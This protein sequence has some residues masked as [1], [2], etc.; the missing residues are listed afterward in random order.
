MTLKE[1]A[2]EFLIAGLNPLPL[3]E[4]KAPNLPRG[5]QFLYQ[6][7]ESLF[8]FDSAETLKIGI[9][10]G[11]VSENFMCIDFD[12]HQGQNIH[13]IFKAYTDSDYFRLLIKNKKVSTVKT[14]RG[15][16][17]IP[18]RCYET[19]PGCTLARWNDGEVMI[20]IRGEGQYIASFPSKG[21]EFIKGCSLVDLQPLDETEVT[22]LLERAAAFNADGGFKKQKTGST[23]KDSARKWP[24]EWPD[25]TPDGIYNN[26]EAESAKNLL[27]KHGWKL[28]KNFRKID[29]IE[30]WVRP[31]KSEDEGI[32]ATFGRFNNMFY[33]FTDAKSAHPFEDH[34][35]YSPFM[36]LVLLEYGG[37]WK[38]AKDDLCDLYGLPRWEVPPVTKTEKPHITHQDEENESVVYDSKINFPLEILPQDYQNYINATY[39]TLSFSRDFIACTML[40]AIATCIGNKAKIKVKTG[41]V[42]SPIFWM[43]M[44]GSRGANKTHPVKGVLAPLFQL[45]KDSYKLYTAQLEEFNALSEEN[46][47]KTRRPRFKQVVVADFTVEALHHALQFNS[48]GVLLYKDELVG[49]FKDMNKYRKSGGDEEFFLESFNNGS[50]IIN[51]KTQDT[52]RLDHI[53]INVIGT[54]QNGVLTE[55]AKA[56]SENGLLDRFL[57]TKTELFARPLSR[58]N[59]DESYITWWRNKVY[60]IAKEM[61][62]NFPEDTIE[63]SMSDAGYNYMLEVEGKYA[64]IQNSEDTPQ[65]LHAYYSKMRTYF[66]RFAL[67]IM[68]IEHFEYGTDLIIDESHIQKAETL[69]KYFAATA[70]EI[71]SEN[72]KQNEYSEIMMSIRGKSTP[73]KIIALH[74]KGYKQTEISKIMKISRQTV[75]KHIPKK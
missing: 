18:F 46:K 14:P 15:G 63:F 27:S 45:E 2:E 72:S 67:L 47:K 62:Y 3:R 22:F 54:I 17:H 10:C 44:V 4:N 53:F 26:T 8:N 49:F 28:A 13:E 57:F 42:D 74:N 75:S 9:A 24:D 29:D 73:E 1:T 59:L 55:L 12:C 70:G 39:N 52:V 66:K 5:H 69:I 65:G 48:K 33:V 23:V 56:H 30:Y 31:G 58:E 34:T 68:I 64:D 7:N 36:I 38:A 71:F 16:Y 11:A 43:A 41:Y 6:R 50:H 20:E 35:A 21:Y 37:N 19:R 51:R 60:L 32:S 25:D 61:N 40:M